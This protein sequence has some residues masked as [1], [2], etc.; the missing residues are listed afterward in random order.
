MIECRCSSEG[1]A[2]SAG[3]AETVAVGLRASGG[4]AQQITRDA[5]GGAPQ[6]QPRLSKMGRSDRKISLDSHG[7]FDRRHG[8]AGL[9]RFLRADARIC[10]ELPSLLV[11]VAMRLLVEQA[12][13][14]IVKRLRGVLQAAGRSGGI[15]GVPAEPV[16][17]ILQ[18]AIRRCND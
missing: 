9:E 6:S 18:A 11:L 8:I 10:W 4:D 17:E 3:N 5:D 1:R 15:R 12:V 2:Q 14:V 13:L 16:D 7:G